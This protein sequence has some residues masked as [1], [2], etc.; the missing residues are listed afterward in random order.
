MLSLLVWLRFGE[1]CPGSLITLVSVPS[2]PGSGFLVSLSLYFCLCFSFFSFPLFSGTL[3]SAWLV[4]HKFLACPPVH[5]I[6]VHV[7]AIILHF[8]SICLYY[9]LKCAF[10]CIYLSQSYAAKGYDMIGDSICGAT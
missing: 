9:V 6:H 2:L 5:S 8:L 1:C 4:Q 10:K 3:N 7:L